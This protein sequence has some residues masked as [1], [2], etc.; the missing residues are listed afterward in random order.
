LG[1]TVATLGPIENFAE[2]LFDIEQFL[3]VVAANQ[4]EVF[5]K[6][7]RTARYLA[8]AERGVKAFESLPAS[9]GA[10]TQALR[11]EDPEA[12]R[13]F[14]ESVDN[15]LVPELC[16][17]GFEIRKGVASWDEPDPR[18][19]GFF[20]ALLTVVRPRRDPFRYGYDGSPRSLDDLVLNLQGLRVRVASIRQRLVACELEESDVFRP[21]NVDPVQLLLVL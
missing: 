7:F 12:S 21:S 1:D 15:T 5:G 11:T 4:E 18:R 20:E 6:G 19:P 2:C 17:V 16:A 14:Q 10:F 9:F 3:V 8:S 13:S